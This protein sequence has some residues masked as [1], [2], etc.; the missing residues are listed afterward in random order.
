MGQKIMPKEPIV[1]VGSACRFAGDVN[2]PSKLW[3]LLR[4]PQDVRSEIFDSRFS[5]KGFYHPNPNYHGHMNVKHSYLLNE[6]PTAFDAEFFGINPLEARAMDPQQRLLL[7]TVYESIE[8]AGMTVEGLQGSDTAVFAG[9]MTGDYEAML[10][11]G[12]DVGPTYCAVGTSRAILSNRISYFFD[13]HGASVTMD[14]ACSSSLVALHSAVQTLRE[15]DSR[16]AIACGSNVILGPENYIIESKVKMLSPDGVSRMWDKD[17]NGYARGDGVAAIALKTL[18]AALEDNDHI[19]C[20]IRETG[21]N[22]DGTTTGLTMP[23]ATAQ[24]ALIQ[25]TYAKLGL[26]PSVEADRPQ[27]FEAHGTG[28]PAGGEL[29]SQA[30]ILHLE[31]IPILTRSGRSRRSRGHQQCLLRARHQDPSKQ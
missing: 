4:D 15:G 23:S 31:C 8:S 3:E 16:M 10:L 24:R 6:D 9:V 20:V 22:Q 7:E 25:R 27:Y 12:M 21:L 30:C 17:A 26:D 2:T 18:S 11:R 14:T 29:I 13:W 19:E 5:V 1:I 28:T